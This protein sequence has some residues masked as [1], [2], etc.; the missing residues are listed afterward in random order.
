MSKS[1]IEE[2]YEKEKVSNPSPWDGVTERRKDW[3]DVVLD[4]LRENNKQLRELQNS[5]NAQVIL[6]NNHMS[7]F[8]EAFPNKDPGSH[9]EYH[10]AVMKNLERKEKLQ[11]AIIEK[12]LAGLVWAIISGIGIAI[13]HYVQQHFK[14]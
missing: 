4:L 9:R 7:D 6:L 2:L 1:T 8:L 3:N 14:A 11:N 13:L 10:E 12:S 5:H